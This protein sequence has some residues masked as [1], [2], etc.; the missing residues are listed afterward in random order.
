MRWYSHHD[1][2]SQPYFHDVYNKKKIYTNKILQNIFSNLGISCTVNEQTYKSGNKYPFQMD[3]P[4]YLRVSTKIRNDSWKLINRYF[5]GGGT[6]K[7]KKQTKKEG[8]ERERENLMKSATS[9]LFRIYIVLDK[10][11][12]QKTHTHISIYETR[13]PDKLNFHLIIL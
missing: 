1:L 12:K 11:T 3:F 13:V 2:L 9:S 10:K 8:G 7:N 6:K 4:S 5:A